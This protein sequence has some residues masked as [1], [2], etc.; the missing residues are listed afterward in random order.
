[1][2][3]AT[4]ANPY[5]PPRAAV[6]ND[7]ENGADTSFKLNLFSAAGRIGR[8]RYLTYSMGISL[9]VMV[10][11]GIL[12]ALISPYLFVLAYIAL[13][14]AQFMLT[15][16]RSHDFNTS[17]WLSLVLLVPI[18]SLIFVFIP[19]T[20]GANRFGNKT[21]PNGNAGVI[22]IALVV[23]I[24]VIGI[25]AAIAIPQYAQYVAKAKAAQAQQQ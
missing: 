8:V 9:L 7:V 22:A 10:V 15:I 4:A 19:G 21:A 5:S 1:M 20:D 24:A 17:G 18:A 11:G 14:Y 16:K 25:L 13:F 6:G 3:D 2:T 23:G 12:A